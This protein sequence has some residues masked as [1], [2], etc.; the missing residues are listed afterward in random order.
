MQHLFRVTA[1]Q[2]TH[3]RTSDNAEG[4]LRSHPDTVAVRPVTALVDPADFTLIPVPPPPVPVPYE[5]AN[6]RARA[7]LEIAGLLATV[8]TTLD[9]L[10]GND[11]IIARAAW[12]SGAALVRT[13]PTV[14]A[15]AAALALAPEQVDALFVQAAALEV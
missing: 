14:I 2:P 8:E 7:V 9:A 4:V 13:G 12:S 15:L 11:G 6:W 5:I 1:T 10:P 3:V